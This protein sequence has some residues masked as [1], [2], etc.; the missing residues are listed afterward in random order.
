MPGAERQTPMRTATNDSAATHTAKLL[1]IGRALGPGWTADQDREMRY[2]CVNASLGD[3]SRWQVQLRTDLSDKG[4]GRACVQLPDDLERRCRRCGVAY[5]GEHFGQPRAAG[6]SL[7]RP[8]A[9]VGRELARRLLTPLARKWIADTRVRL[10]EH[11]RAAAAAW[12]LADQLADAGLVT[13]PY[14]K[15]D[16]ERARLRET[17]VTVRTMSGHGHAR[18]MHAGRGLYIDRVTIE[19]PAIARQV[20]ELV[21]LA[22][23]ED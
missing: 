7:D 21:A 8:A 13:L 5:T 3:G 20:L 22:E 19:D 18:I 12:K 15:D 10:R 1:E 14:Q 16:E 9:E 17:Q 6:F 4:R 23:K 2:P 11:R